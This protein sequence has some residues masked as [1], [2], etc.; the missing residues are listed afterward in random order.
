MFPSSKE[1]F[2][3]AKKVAPGGVHSPV[4][5]FRSVGGDPI[6][7]QSG[8]GAKLTDVSG[9]EYIDYCLSFGPLILGHRDEDV[10]K[11]VSET[12][13]LAWSFGAAEP[14]SLELAE[15]IVSK[16]PWVEKIRFVNSGTEAVM[17]ALRVAR[18]ATGRD[19]ILKFDGCYHGHLDAL[20]VKAG[21]GLAGES[22]SDSAGIG[23]ELIKNTLVLPLDDEKAVEELFAKEGKN[24]AALVI[25]PLPA[26]YGLLIQRKEFLSKIV[27][28]ARKHGTLVLFDEVISGFRVGLTGMSGEL[29]IAPDLVTYGKIIGGGFPV[30]AYA[31]KAELLDLVAPQG[32]VYQAGT[33][34][35]SPFGMRAGLATVQK[36]EKDNVWNV[37]ENRTKSFVS[38]MVS[39][40]RERDPEGD[41]DSSVHSSLFWFHKKSSSPI[42][43]VDKIPVGHKEGFA[44][45]F[46]ALLAEGIYLAPSGYEVGF[47]SYAHSDK[48]LSETLEKADSALKKLKV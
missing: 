23:S 37:L 5:S 20:L 4:R 27:E 13:E 15:W 7:F 9:K 38:G 6:F 42:R 25:E 16:I 46:H 31:G 2:E 10:Q 48:I 32:P 21:S 22:S 24:I 30:G 17:S 19:K 45:V 44:K 26:N 41:W 33:L 3:R 34:S 18:A 47:L 40:L 39:I 14:Y 12:A 28:I 35:A 1:L 36:C 8:K 29:G 43:T 11:I